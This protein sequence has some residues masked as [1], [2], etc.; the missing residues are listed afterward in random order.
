M[1]ILIFILLFFLV[2]GLMFVNNYNLHLSNEEELKNFSELYF[3]W[4]GQ[5]YSNFF[6]MT[7][8]FSRLNWL[9]K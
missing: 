7:G 4:F 2:V 1:K 8:H 6:S 9:P 3:N 5:I